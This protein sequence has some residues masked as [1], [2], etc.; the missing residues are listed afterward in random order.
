M[1]SIMKIYD[2][3]VPR[4]DIQKLLSYNEIVDERSDVRPDVI[5][6]HPRWDV[7]EWPQEV[8]E[9]VL[10]QVL[11]YDYEVEEVIFN[12]SKISFRLHADSGKDDLAR[13][14]HA[15]L[16]PMYVDGPAHTVFFD[17]HW[18]SNSTKF[19]KREILPFEYTLLNKKGEWQYIPD[20]RDL[21]VAAKTYP[22]TVLDFDVS[23]EFIQDLQRIIEVR[24]NQ[25][26]A[27]VDDRCYDYTNV[28]NYNPKIHIDKEVYDH[29]LNHIEYETVDGLTIANIAEWVPGRVIV[30]ER[31]RLHC[32]SSCH[33]QKIGITLFTRKKA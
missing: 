26:I 15:V 33:T 19:S 27:K 4:E 22:K 32:A 24:S 6:K 16:I 25:G 14:G 2:N 17:N 18:H 12:N 20:V 23:Q 30:F 7:D 21:L 9:R 28:T 31:T 1:Q 13:Q 5:S 29:Y 8:V 10:N 3:L 11:D